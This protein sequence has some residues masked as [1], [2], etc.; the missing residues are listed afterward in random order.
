M[1]KLIK[2]LD[3]WTSDEDDPDAT[4]YRLVLW[5]DGEYALQLWGGLGEPKWYDSTQ[6]WEL[7]ELCHHLAE[8][9][10]LPGEGE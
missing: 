5:S 9:G 3:E 4:R 6:G 1:G 10:M 7:N 2:V 8:R